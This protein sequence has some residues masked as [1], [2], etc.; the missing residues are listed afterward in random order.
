MGEVFTSS[1][2]YPAVAIAQG[3]I[4]YSPATNHQSL[5]TSHYSPAPLAL[6]PPHGAIFVLG[7]FFSVFAQSDTGELHDPGGNLSGSILTEGGLERQFSVSD[8]G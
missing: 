7:S 3:R 5:V 8:L 2:T 6:C 4:N 1:T